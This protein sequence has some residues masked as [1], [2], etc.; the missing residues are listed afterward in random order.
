MVWTVTQATNTPEKTESRPDT[1]G[2]LVVYGATR[3]G[4]TTGADI[5]WT[6]VAGG[7]EQQLALAGDQRNPNISG[8]LIAFES[9]DGG[10]L[11]PNLAP[12]EADAR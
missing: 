7:A 3:S 5:Y 8:N 10:D 11:T 12:A 2:A 4:S 6:P 1:N 9:R